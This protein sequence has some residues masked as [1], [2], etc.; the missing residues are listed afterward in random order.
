MGRFGGP[1]LHKVSLLPCK[2]IHLPGRLGW[3]LYR[4]SS[5]CLQKGLNVH[6][7]IALPNDGSACSCVRNVLFVHWTPGGITHFGIAFP[8]GIGFMIFEAVKGNYL[9]G[10]EKEILRA[11]DKQRKRMILCR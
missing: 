2:R 9:K 5:P 8:F 10:E 3:N 1:I 11:D 6:N 4:L 7:Q